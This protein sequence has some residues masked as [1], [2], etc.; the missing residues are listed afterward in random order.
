MLSLWQMFSK[1]DALEQ[2]LNPSKIN[3][4]WKRSTAAFF[5][6]LVLS[7]SASSRDERDRIYSLLDLHCPA[8]VVDIVVDCNY[9]PAQLNLPHLFLSHEPAN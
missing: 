8:D 9:A 6:L 5:G 3:L 7:R 2:K 1:A 4:L